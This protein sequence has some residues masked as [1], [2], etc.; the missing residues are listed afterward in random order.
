MGYINHKIEG[1]LKNTLQRGK[2]N[3]LLGTRQI[4]K[5]RLFLDEYENASHGFVICRSPRRI[6]LDDKTTAA[7][8]TAL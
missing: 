3:L 4:G 7:V 6:R 2:R 1:M 5:I 8:A